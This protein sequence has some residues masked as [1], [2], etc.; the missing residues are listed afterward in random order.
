[1]RTNFRTRVLPIALLVSISLAAC[2]KKDE[3]ATNDIAVPAAPAP[4]AIKVTE[5]ETG[6]S[7][8][9]DK[10]VMSGLDAFGVRDTIYV[11]VKTEGASSS[12][13]LTAKWTYNDSQVV[14]ENTETIAPTGTAYTEFHISKPSGWPKGKYRVDISLDGVESGSKEFVVQ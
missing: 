6:K 8:S 12:S 10:Q 7:I 4:S 14:S 11:A 2:G 3:P 9:T 13:K 1:V 5:I